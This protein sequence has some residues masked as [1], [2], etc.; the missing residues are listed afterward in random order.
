MGKKRP[1]TP[2][3]V[4]PAGPDITECAD[5]H[6][7]RH[8]LART[9]TERSLAGYSRRK[10]VPRTVDTPPSRSTRQNRPVSVD[11]FLATMYRVASFTVYTIY[12]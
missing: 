10:S 4:D 11:G 1:H 6:P 2:T 12:H 3:A 5:R 9:R 7:L 8:P